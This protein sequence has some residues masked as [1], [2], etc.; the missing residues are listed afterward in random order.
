MIRLS[1]NSPEQIVTLSTEP[2]INVDVD[3]T[4][5]PELATVLTDEPNVITG[6]ANT[7]STELSAI[8]ANDPSISVG[9]V[10]TGAISLTYIH[11]QIM[12][13]SEWVIS[14]GLGRYP[15]VTVVDSAGSVVYGD[16]KYMSRDEVLITFASEFSGKAYFN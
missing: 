4:T 13:S 6:V 16:V 1:Q 9:V 10:S 7:T 2:T 8:L 14:H 3:N 5:S 15:S 11:E 12:S